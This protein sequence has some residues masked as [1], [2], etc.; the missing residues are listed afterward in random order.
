VACVL[1]I[2]SI[3]L[4][5]RYGYKQADEDVDRWIAAILYGSIA[6]SACV[7]DAL[8]VR[9]WFRGARKSGGFTGVVASLAFLVTFTNSLG[10]IASRADAVQAQR[11]AATDSRADGRRELKRLEDALAGLRFV[12]TDETAVAAAKH[13]A[14]VAASNRQAEC[15]KRGP[16]CRQRE[17]DD[18]ETARKLA[19]ATTNKATT[20][21]ANL[22]E[23]QIAAVK[24][25]LDKPVAIG[26]A[27][28]LGAALANIIGYAPDNLT[29]WQQAIIALAYELCLVGMMVGYTVLSEVAA[30]P[31]PSKPAKQEPKEERKQEA[32]KLEPNNDGGPNL[33]VIQGG[34]V[35]IL[36]KLLERAPRRRVAI[37]DLYRAYATQTKPEDRLS[38]VTFAE[39][40]AKFCRKIGIRTSMV[41][42]KA[43]LVG[44]RL[45]PS[46][47][48][49]VT[50]CH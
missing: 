26:Q 42:G 19:E 1:A 35:P 46:V 12:P 31:Q 23:S 18:Q 38:P 32:P 2:V 25:K 36:T 47:E 9:L 17:L 27:N 3:A 49:V 34:L 14:E 10:G 8:A 30:M 20:D 43:Y 44:V 22:L 33:T 41:D 37:D 6:L 50:S 7:F 4:T 29:S 24:T 28:P 16:N 40:V 39:E 11:Q 13:A 45:V 48:Q 5:A 21:R 15:D